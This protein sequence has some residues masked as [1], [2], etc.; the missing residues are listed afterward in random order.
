MTSLNSVV[1]VTS[2]CCASLNHGKEPA[3]LF[4]VFCAVLD[5]TLST[6]N[7]RATGADIT[8]VNDGDIVVIAADVALSLIVI[9][10]QPNTFEMV[11]VRPV[12]LILHSN[13]R[14]SSDA[15]LQSP[16]VV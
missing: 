6:D 5:S 13:H 12:V 4:S 8:S 11:C 2:I 10:D 16:S 9:T 7:V 14:L 3:A 15:S 1:I